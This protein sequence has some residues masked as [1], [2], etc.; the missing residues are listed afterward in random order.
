V[1]PSLGEILCLNQKKSLLIITFSIAPEV[2][3][4]SFIESVFST[5]VRP[6]SAIT[7][8]NTFNFGVY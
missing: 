3:L 5:F 1:S 2:A 6:K 8:A 7:L 4:S